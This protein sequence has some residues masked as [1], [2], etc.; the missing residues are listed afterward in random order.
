MLNGKAIQQYLV[1]LLGILGNLPDN[2]RIF[3]SDLHGLLIKKVINIATEVER[4]QKHIEGQYFPKWT[5]HDHFCTGILLHFPL[6]QHRWQNIESSNEN[7]LGK[8]YWLDSWQRKD[9]FQTD[10]NKVLRSF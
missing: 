1:T 10:L 6:Q 4:T 8:S 9:V 3:L 7:E 2:R 5:K